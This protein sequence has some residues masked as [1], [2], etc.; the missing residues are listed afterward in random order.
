MTG[1]REPAS[2][3]CER[4]RVRKCHGA[5]AV[6]RTSNAPR[7]VDRVSGAGMFLPRPLLRGV[8][9]F[10]S[11]CSRGRTAIVCPLLR[12]FGDDCEFCIEQSAVDHL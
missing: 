11:E 4:A 1:A 3:E 10:S 12:A 9:P 8:P 6:R 7:A 2:I 5:N